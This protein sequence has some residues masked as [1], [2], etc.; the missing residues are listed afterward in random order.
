VSR[1]IRVMEAPSREIDVEANFEGERL[2]GVHAVLYPPTI[3]VLKR[4][5]GGGG[6]LESKMESSRR[7]GREKSLCR[8]GLLQG[9]IPPA[10]ARTQA[11]LFITVGT[12]YR[13]LPFWSSI[14]EICGGGAFKSSKSLWLSAQIAAWVRLFA[15]IFL[16]MAFT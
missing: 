14:G 1:L 3:A 7:T 13:L 9:S 5:E 8:N 12:V 2:G 10:P 15:P 16:K 11:A 6:A 4:G